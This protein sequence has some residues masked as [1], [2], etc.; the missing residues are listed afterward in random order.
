[1]RNMKKI[2]IFITILSSI[3]IINIKDNNVLAESIDLTKSGDVELHTDL[4]VTFAEAYEGG[5]SYL[6]KFNATDYDLNANINK[7]I[8]Y[9]IT[10]YN[11]FLGGNNTSHTDPLSLNAA[12]ELKLT[13]LASGIE[14]KLDDYQYSYTHLNFSLQLMT[15]N[16]RL[17][18]IWSLEDDVRFPAHRQL[19]KEN[20]PITSSLGIHITRKDNYKNV[21]YVDEE[22][23]IEAVVDE[24]IPNQLTTTLWHRLEFIENSIYNVTF[25]TNGGT[26]YAPIEIAADENNEYSFLDLGIELPIPEKYGHDFIEWV[27]YDE[28]NFKRKFT[29]ETKIN[30]DLTIE[31]RYRPHQDFYHFRFYSNGATDPYWKPTGMGGKVIEVARGDVINKPLEI[32]FKRGY[33]FIGWSR[34]LNEYVA[35]DFNTPLLQNITVNAFYEKVEGATINFVTNGGSMVDNPGV[36]AFGKVVEYERPEKSRNS[37]IG[38]FMDE[39]LTVSAP[40]VLNGDNINHYDLTLY[41]KWQDNSGTLYFETN[42][43]PKMSPVAAEFGQRIVLPNHPPFREGYIFKG[44]YQDSQLSILVPEFFEF[45]E[46]TTVYVGW[47]KDVDYKDDTSDESHDVLLYVALGLV[48]L[49]IIVA[50]TTPS[51]RRW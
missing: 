14:V 36:Y 33:K 42:G 43:G 45:I 15:N 12:Y 21:L 24:F 30:S 25:K 50:I 31:A 16:I 44:W 2:L 35:Y 28:Y 34:S 26:V 48:G 47:E 13:V 8:I 49:G 9:D 39:E 19:L 6:F 41:A 17:V 32:P 20:Q 7:T 51:K 18:N 27:Y 22:M 1:M 5:E 37:F 40:K 46:T 4:N 3:F 11:Y 29:V 10:N 38:W 23:T